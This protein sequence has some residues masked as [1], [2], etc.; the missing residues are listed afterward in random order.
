ME[1]NNGS[2]PAMTEVREKNYYPG[3][4][5]FASGFLGPQGDVGFF[6]V[7]DVTIAHNIIKSLLSEGRRITYADMGLDGDWRENS[8]TVYESGEYKDYDAYGE[9]QWAEPLMIVY[10]SDSPSETYSVWHR[11]EKRNN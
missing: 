11:E 1:S 9:S 3:S 2:K 7:A 6:M 5:S 8:C 10:F 4:I